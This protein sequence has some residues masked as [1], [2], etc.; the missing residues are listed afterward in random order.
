MDT[1]IREMD[2]KRRENLFSSFSGGDPAEK[3]KRAR[4]TV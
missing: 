1:H 3:G 2:L 4:G